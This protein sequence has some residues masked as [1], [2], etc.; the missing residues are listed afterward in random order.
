MLEFVVDEQGRPIV[1]GTIAA[2]LTLRCQR[3]LEPMVVSLELP[4]RLALVQSE[5]EEQNL[6]PGF[7]A[8][9]VGERPIPLAQIVEDELILGLPLV[10]MHPEQ[11]CKVVKD[12]GVDAGEG[13]DQSANP[14]GV[15]ATLK[16]DRP[17]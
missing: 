7:E 10:P 9:M 6:P 3:C 17:R 5:A 1:Q 16:R 14:F 2:G 8:L 15:L 4:V 11:A 12:Y 13:A